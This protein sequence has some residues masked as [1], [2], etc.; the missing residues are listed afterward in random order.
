MVDLGDEYGRGRLANRTE[1]GQSPD[2]VSMREYAL[3]IVQ[4]RLAISFDV[5]D[6]SRD[7]IIASEHTLDLAAKKRRERST[8]SSLH[9]I[10][11][12]AEAFADILL[13]EPDAMQS[14]QPFDPPDD[15]NALLDQVL[16]LTF[17]TLRVLLLDAWNLHRTGHLA[18]S[19]Q[20]SSENARHTLRIE[21][22]G[23]GNPA[24]T[25]H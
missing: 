11:P 20:P 3:F 22:V 25:R 19:R 1:R 7:Q 10:K 21:A 8:V 4:C 17:Y 2:L 5:R 16:P 23:L 24:P 15:A 18:V 9:C 12:L 14:Q 13:N 6:L